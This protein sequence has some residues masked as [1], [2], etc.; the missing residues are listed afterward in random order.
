MLLCIK[1]RGEARLEGSIYVFHWSKDLLPWEPSEGKKGLLE[2][3]S[4]FYYCMLTPFNEAW[5]TLKNGLG[6]GII[7]FEQNGLGRRNILCSGASCLPP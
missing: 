1:V 7:V 4:D 3:E 6:F 5:R 2:G